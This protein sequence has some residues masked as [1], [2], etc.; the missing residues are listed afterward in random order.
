ME[1]IQN[2]SIQILAVLAAKQRFILY[3]TYDGQLLP[4][5]LDAMRAVLG[6]VFSISPSI[7]PILYFLTAPST[8]PSGL[9]R[10]GGI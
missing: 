2:D 10:M 4:S 6:I 7:A 8:A 1:K 9:H 3:I 5:S